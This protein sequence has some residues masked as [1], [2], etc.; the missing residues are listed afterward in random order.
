MRIRPYESA[1]RDACLSIFRSNV[2]EYVAAFEEEQYRRFL[3]NAP[4]TYFVLVREDGRV[5]AA[6]GY[7][8]GADDVCTLCWGL[9]HRQWH[10]QG[11]GRQ[12]LTARLDAIEQAGIARA[13]R[14][15]TSQ[16]TRG[17]FERF[18]FVATETVTNGIAPGIDRV[19][20]RLE[21]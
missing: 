9:V 5:A 3:D 14:L 17:F 8:I 12:L 6:G 20:M 13:V 1:D 11:L 2:P 4:G 16:H 7:A 18:G 21:L 19:D 15:S 10:R